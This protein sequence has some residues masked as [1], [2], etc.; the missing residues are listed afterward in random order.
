M[1]RY[2]LNKKYFNILVFILSTFFICHSMA[3]MSKNALSGMQT[4]TQSKANLAV[5][6]YRLLFNQFT[7]AQVS[8][9]RSFMR[10][11]SGYQSDNIITQSSISTEINYSS[12][13]SKDLLVN[14][15]RRTAQHLGMQVLVRS[16]AQQINI[17]FIQLTP[18]SLPYKQW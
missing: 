2:L 5:L 11:Y 3:A 18:K 13:A 16:S 1:Q 8:Q 6:E 17:R 7:P 4:T 10:Q 14:N 9:M 15:F 12:S